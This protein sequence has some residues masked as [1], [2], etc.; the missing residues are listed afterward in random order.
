MTLGVAIVGAVAGAG[1]AAGHLGP[2]FARAT[3]AGW[4][5]I[6][7]LGVVVFVLGVTTTTRWADQTARATADRFREPTARDQYAREGVAV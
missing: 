3:H 4:W 6:T 7:A 5:I 2:A 1:A